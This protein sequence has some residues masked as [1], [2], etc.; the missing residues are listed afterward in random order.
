MRGIAGRA[1]AVRLYRRYSTTVR[2][3]HFPQLWSDTH[4][5]FLPRIHRTTDPD[6]DRCKT[7]Q[8]F[9]LGEVQA[10]LAVVR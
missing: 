8:I 2:A 1:A 4:R 9:M 10:A 5:A 6:D 7:E 3:T